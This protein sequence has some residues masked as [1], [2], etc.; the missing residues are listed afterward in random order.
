VDAPLLEVKNLTFAYD[1][2]AMSFDLSLPRGGIMAVIGASGAGK[3]TLLS[4][5]AGFDA[6]TGGTVTI[7]GVDVTDLAPARR[8][9][10]M[11]FQEHNLFPHLTAAQN[12]GLGLHPGLRLAKSDHAAVEAALGRVG[13]AGM[14][15]RLPRQLSGG[16]R[17]RVA[18]ARSLVRNRPL[19]LLD[20]PFA[21]L[22]PALKHDMLDLVDRLRRE[23]GISVLMVSHDPADA[24]RIAE[25]TAFVAAGHIV[26]VGPT[27]EI[28]DRP[29]TREIADY[30]GIAHG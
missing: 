29:P 27:A 7:G 9:V 24:R 18:L 6:P 25:T 16:E 28:L 3:T 15:G 30:L 5:I 13:M 23:T 8:P 12:I 17:Q 14:G 20:E 4:L 1:D 22:G 11:L 21:A 19:L 26:A 10:T 2:Q